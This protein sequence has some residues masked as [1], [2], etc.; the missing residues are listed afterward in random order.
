MYFI[1]YVDRVNVATAASEIRRDL[2][3]S[4][5]QLGFVFSAFAYPYLLFQVFGGW[6]GD[7]FGPRRTLFLCGLVW[8]SATILTGLPGS[9]A[10][11]P[12]TARGRWQVGRVGEHDIEPPRAHR[13]EQVSMQHPHAAPVQAGVG[14]RAYDGRPA[15]VNGCDGGR[16][17]GCGHRQD[18]ASRAQIEH[19]SP[20]ARQRAVQQQPG[21]RARR[22][23][24]GRGDKPQPT[25]PGQRR[26]HGRSST[27]E[28]IVEN[29]R[30]LSRAVF[31]GANS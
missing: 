9:P 30:A 5:T 7:R 18:A 29:R 24:P 1:T 31:P 12:A 6:I 15:C 20:D 23:H 22:E 19:L 3:L 28:P 17:V 14:T 4:N 8:A 27:P 2:A 11:R 16:T 26:L 13:L 21:V 25:K 10:E